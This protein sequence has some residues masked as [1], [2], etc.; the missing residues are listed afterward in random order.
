MPALTGVAGLPPGCEK[1]GKGA[2]DGNS[3]G[4][5]PCGDG[6]VFPPQH[7][8]RAGPVLEMP[9]GVAALTV[10]PGQL[11]TEMGSTAALCWRGIDCHPAAKDGLGLET[12]RTGV[13]Q[14]KVPPATPLPLGLGGIR[15]GLSDVVAL[16][17]TLAQ[18]WM[19]SNAGYPLSLLSSPHRGRSRCPLPWC[20]PWQAAVKPQQ[21]GPRDAGWPC[22]ATLRHATQRDLPRRLEQVDYRHLPFPRLL[23]GEVFTMISLDA[24]F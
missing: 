3:Q 2:R 24:H 9:I 17:V 1:L 21:G 15:D 7:P 23:P 13:P 6:R 19:G 22:C 16:P 14:E 8:G 4:G 5:S 20:W 12:R 18:W 11:G 10:G